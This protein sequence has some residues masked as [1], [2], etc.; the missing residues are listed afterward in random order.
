MYIDPSRLNF[1]LLV[2]I[3]N[4][5]ANGYSVIEWDYGSSIANPKPTAPTVP[6]LLTF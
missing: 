2:E 4:I 6:S 5:S 3:Y 1:L